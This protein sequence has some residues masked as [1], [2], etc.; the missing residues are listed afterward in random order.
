MDRSKSSSRVVYAFEGKG[1]DVYVCRGGGG[2][3]DGN[4]DVS[5]RGVDQ[6]H[7]GSVVWWLWAL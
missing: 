5:N 6:S 4:V 2:G 3:G 7:V 1:V